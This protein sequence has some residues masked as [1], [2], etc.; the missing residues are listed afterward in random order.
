MGSH[1]GRV[2]VIT[3]AAGGIGRATAERIEAEGGS[4]IAFDRDEAALRWTDGHDRV[5]SVVGDVTSEDANAAAVAEAIGRHGALDTMILNAGVPASGDLLDLD[6]DVFD[7]AIDVNVRAVVL[8]IRA[9]VPDLRRSGN[10][11]IVI[12]ASTSGL[13]GDPGHWPYNTSKGAVV[14]LARAVALDLGPD[15]IR[16]NAVCP[17]PTA[18]AM[19]AG[20]TREPE[21]FEPLR[22]RIPL[23]RW[24]EPAE[25]AAVI[26]FLASPDASFVTGAVVPVDGG[27]TANTGQFLPRPR[28]KD[29]PR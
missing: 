11:A 10:G 23:Q 17:G 25:V 26:S 22:R 3:G 21:R 24:A 20:L 4:V 13:A 8:G 2:A 27:I 19:T 6:L 16:V 9:A 12:T 18:T 7:T 28:T 5:T 1:D 29:E 15:G 14:N